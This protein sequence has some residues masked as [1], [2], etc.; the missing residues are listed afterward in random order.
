M[1][2]LEY[3]SSRALGLQDSVLRTSR[4]THLATH[5]LVLFVQGEEGEK[6]LIE[7]VL[8]LKVTPVLR[9]D[10]EQE[11]DRHLSMTT[12]MKDSSV[13]MYSSGSPW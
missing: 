8:R 2:P 1:C 6:V 13:I 12:V 9:L 11:G 3:V 10:V 5:I 4:L 7:H